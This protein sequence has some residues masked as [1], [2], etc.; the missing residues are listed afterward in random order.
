VRNE[1]LT[2]TDGPFA[3]THEVLGGFYLIDVPDLEAAV[4]VAERHPGAKLGTV[5]IRPLLE[6]PG[7]P[8]SHR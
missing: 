4:R 3:E 7:L 1:K 2:V 6:L 8:D 5:E